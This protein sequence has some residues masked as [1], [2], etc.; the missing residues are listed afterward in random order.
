MNVTFTKMKISNSDLMRSR[1]GHQEGAH[2]RG[3][4]S[5]CA[6]VRDGGM[7]TGCDLGEHGDQSSE[8]IENEIAAPAHGILDFGTE[9][10]KENHVTDDVGPTAVHEHRGQERDQVVTRRDLC[11]NR[12]PLDDERITASQLKQ[13]NE[14]IHD[15]D[16]RGAHGRAY[17]PARRIT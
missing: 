10:P 6:Q 1:I 11:R 12:R 2:H 8:Q 13:K 15:D 17:R 16:D 9:G 5:A 14:D 3:N 7:R 4:G